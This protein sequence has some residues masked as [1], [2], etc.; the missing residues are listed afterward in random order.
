MCDELL[1]T[2]EQMMR[3]KSDVHTYIFTYKILIIVEA[4]NLSSQNDKCFHGYNCVSKNI[5]LKTFCY[6]CT[7]FSFNSIN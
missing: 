2:E 4:Q 1:E 7:V 5:L 3:V 6:C